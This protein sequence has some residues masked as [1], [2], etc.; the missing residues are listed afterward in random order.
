M[1]KDRFRTGKIY[2]TE[3]NAAEGIPVEEFELEISN[4]LKF[5][6]KDIDELK[7]TVFLLKEIE[8]YSHQEIAE[9]LNISVSFSRTILCRTKEL[10]SRRIESDGGIK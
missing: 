9:V 3:L 10:L 1:K 6:L 7:R 4:E 2:F 8:G 5:Y